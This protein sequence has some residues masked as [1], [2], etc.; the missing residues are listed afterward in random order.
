MVDH[1]GG[2]PDV[3]IV[4]EGHGTSSQDAM[5]AAVR[6]NGGVSFATRR[7]LA[8]T[9]WDGVVGLPLRPA[10]VMPVFLTWHGTPGRA[11]QR[12]IDFVQPDA[13]P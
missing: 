11:L 1:L 7:H 6:K 10:L 5:I 9:A 8:R 13:E 3:R 4:G 12:L 2:P